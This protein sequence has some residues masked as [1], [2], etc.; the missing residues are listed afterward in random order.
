MS[1]LQDAIA[2]GGRIVLRIALMLAGLLLFGLALAAGAVLALLAYAIVR[3]RGRRPGGLHFA[4]RGPIGG[5]A[6]RWRSATPAART[7][8]ADVVDV[9]VREIEASPASDPQRLGER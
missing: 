5:A 3:L 1:G 7:A 8:S 9:E 2:R 4:W 6:R